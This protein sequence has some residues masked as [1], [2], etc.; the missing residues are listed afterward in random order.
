M[1]E[2]EYRLVPH[3]HLTSLANQ[4]PL[5]SWDDLRNPEKSEVRQML[6]DEQHGLC[7]YCERRLS[8]EHGRIDHVACQQTHAQR[9]FDYSNL[10]HS[11]SGRYRGEEGESEV[12]SCDGFKG[13]KSLGNVKPR[14]G[15]NKL[16]SFNTA[17]GELGANRMLAVRAK[18]DVETALAV[19]GL[20]NSTRLKDDRK[21]LWEDL[22]DLLDDKANPLDLLNPHDEYYW[23][24]KEYFSPQ[25]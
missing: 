24:M 15:V 21:T 2:I 14:P 16:I 11:C 8:F 17:T 5:A 1:V 4:M 18:Q 19:L 20:N 23:T 7:A 6:N 10:C 22:S 13:N 25:P 12:L 9:R 3:P